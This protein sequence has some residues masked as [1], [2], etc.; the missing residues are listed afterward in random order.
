VKIKPNSIKRLRSIL[1]I[2]ILSFLAEDSIRHPSSFNRHQPS[3]IGHRSSVVPPFSIFIFLFS[4]F[5][6]SSCKNDIDEA[7][8]IT[9]RTNTS[10][11]KGTDVEIVFTD[12]GETKIVS[13]AP[14]LLRYATENPTWSFLKV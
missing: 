1:L 2:Q 7:R 8:K 5:I 14:E 9:M 12:Y 10:I 3:V 13:K 4:L 6:V 11:E